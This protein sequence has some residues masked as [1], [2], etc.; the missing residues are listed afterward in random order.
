M[1]IKLFMALI[2]DA[3][4]CLQL[5]NGQGVVPSESN[6]METNSLLFSEALLNVCGENTVKLWLENDALLVGSMVVDREGFVKS[7]NIVRDLKIGLSRSEKK[8]IVKYLKNNKVRFLLCDYQLSKD[9]ICS[10]C[11][12][13]P[14]QTTINRRRNKKNI[15]GIDFNGGSMFWMFQNEKENIHANKLEILKKNI[16]HLHYNA[17]PS[18]L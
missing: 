3:I 5:S 4:T 11:T 18:S 7:L 17:S 1:R 8:R 16:K 14:P 9:T 13:T 2:F 12:S 10:S 6:C 15:I